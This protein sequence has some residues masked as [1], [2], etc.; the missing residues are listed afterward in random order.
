MELPIL[1]FDNYHFIVSVS[2]KF[3]PTNLYTEKLLRFLNNFFKLLKN[4]LLGTQGKLHYKQ[5]EV[6]RTIKSLKDIEFIEIRK[7]AAYLQ[8]QLLYIEIMEHAC[9]HLKLTW[10]PFGEMNSQK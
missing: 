10:V 8:Q 4:T 2:K 9:P 7:K 3:L 1:H 5:T 6:K